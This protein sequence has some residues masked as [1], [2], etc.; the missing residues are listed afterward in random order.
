MMAIPDS[1]SMLAAITSSHF[2]TTVSN[3]WNAHRSPRMKERGGI[4]PK[5]VRNRSKSIAEPATG[6]SRSPPERSLSL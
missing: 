3:S 4:R 1:A 2:S 5:S 6:L